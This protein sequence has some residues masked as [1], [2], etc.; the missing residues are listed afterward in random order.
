MSKEMQV[1]ILVMKTIIAE[2]ENTLH[3]TKDKLNIA[4][5]KRRVSLKQKQEAVSIIDY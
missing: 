4:G 2:V 1:E 3:E 5:G